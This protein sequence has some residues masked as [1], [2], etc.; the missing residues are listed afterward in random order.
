METDPQPY[1]EERRFHDQNITVWVGHVD[2]RNIEGWQGNPRIE[3]LRDQFHETYARDP[4]NEEMCQLALDD[5]DE[6]ESLR[7]KELA[8]NIHKIGVQVPIVLTHSKKLLDGNRRYYASTFLLMEGASRKDRSDFAKIPAYV[9]PKGTS[10]EVEDAILT[11]FNFTKNMQLEWPYYIRARKVYLD[12]DEEGISKEELQHK[13]GTPWRYLS[14][15]IAAARLCDQFLKHHDET[16]TAKQF[17]F[18]NFIMFDEMTR[19]FNQKFR[20]GEFRRAIFDVLLDGYEPENHK[21][22]KFTKSADT[23]RLDEIYESEDAWQALIHGR[24]DKALKEALGI[25][26]MSNLGGST[27]PN[28]ALKRIV[29]GLEKLVKNRNLVSADQDLLQF[30]RDYSQQVP[31]GPTDP[32]AQIEQM[33]TWLEDM[34]AMQI[35]ELDRASVVRLRKAL[36]IITDVAEAV[37]KAVKAND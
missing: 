16:I 10:L 35:A 13:Y 11:E 7:I 6:K 17:A 32:A 26:E 15:W 34:S 21:H 30:F 28:P 2:I 20:D 29:K 27:D 18:R 31:G 37:K 24:G 12:H 33:L 36:A 9:L 8:A 3:L 23:V 5:D 4:T 14:K 1:L 19:N 22:H 25:L